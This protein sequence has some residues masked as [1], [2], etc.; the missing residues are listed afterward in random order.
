MHDHLCEDPN[1]LI[2]EYDGI[3]ADPSAY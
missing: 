1:D 2:C 3:A